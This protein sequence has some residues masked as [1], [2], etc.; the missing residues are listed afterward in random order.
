VFVGY[1][2]YLR[3]ARRLRW[4]ADAIPLAADAA[5]WPSLEPALRARVEPLVAGFCVGE[6][7]V[8]TELEPFAAAA[9]DRDMAACFAMQRIDE[10]RHARFFDRVADEVF[11]FPGDDSDGRRDA[12]RARLDPRFVELFEDRLPAVAGA[13]ASGTGELGTGVGLY[14]M[15]LE[16]VVFTA[17][18]LALLDALASTPLLPGIRRGA[19]L[20]LRDERWHV[21]FGTRCLSGAGIDDGLAARIRR[22]GDDAAYL[23]G[24]V[25]GHDIAT[26]V[27]ATHHRRLR[28]AASMERSVLTRSSDMT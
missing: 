20:V 8:S 4:D 5:A 23:W 10:T 14:H 28:A 27:I 9:G 2:H 3:L 13:L 12:A 17:G 15:V 1:T 22:E 16:G 26:R 25:A 7:Q 18:L 11:A 21:G 24:E 6:A 19:E